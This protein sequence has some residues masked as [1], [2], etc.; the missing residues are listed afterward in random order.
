M[1]TR[2]ALYIVAALLIAAHFLRGGDVIAVAVCLATPLLF[3]VR[4]PWSLL[5]LQGLA[6]AAAG[7]W[8]AQAWHLAAERA[9][10]GQP[11]LRGA[12]ILI[13][14]AAVSMLA[15]GLLGGSRFQARYCGR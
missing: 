3:L 12:A 6:F 1:R 10:F 15:G 14:V 5:V 4:R 9:L 2:I 7:I 13:G 8:L 11:W